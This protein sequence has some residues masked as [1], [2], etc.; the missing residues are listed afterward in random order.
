MSH[1]EMLDRDLKTG[2]SQQR[3]LRCCIE[4]T[5]RRLKDG[6]LMLDYL[7]KLY[8]KERGDIKRLTN[9]NALGVRSAAN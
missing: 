8:M 3:N 1:V 6:C 5:T 4:L 2:V 7:F 9:T